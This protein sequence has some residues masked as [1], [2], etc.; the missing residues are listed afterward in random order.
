MK[1]KRYTNETYGKKLKS[2]S[3]DF[4]AI[5]NYMNYTLIN[6]FQVS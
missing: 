4:L 2:L 3:I 1:G 6:V 5:E